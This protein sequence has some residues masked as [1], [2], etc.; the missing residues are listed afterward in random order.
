MP[1]IPVAL[2][3]LIA[4]GGCF[5]RHSEPPVP[6]RSAARDSLL[7]FDLR[8]VDSLALRG[9][10]A[11][12][13]AYLTADAVYLRGGAPFVFGRENVV[14]MLSAPGSSS[15]ATLGWQ[16]IGG[17]LSRD[18]LC[19]YS[20]GIAVHSVPERVVPAIDRY[21]AFW[22]RTRG[23]SWKIQ[24]YAEVGDNIA[25]PSSAPVAGITIPQPALSKAAAGVVRSLI[26]ADSNFAEASSLFGAARGFGDAIAD[27]GVV[28]GGSEILA[29]ARDVREFFESRRGVSMSWHPMFAMAAASGDLGFTIGES[30]STSRGPSGAAVQRFTKYITVWRRQPN[31]RWKFVVDGGNARPSPV[32]E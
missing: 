28:F 9:L 6:R 19:G 10:P 17:G 2:V 15:A 16:P 8:R 18:G 30:V 3:A 22:T 24:A 32:G 14:L 1:R 5:S 12:M 26:I 13:S 23:G 21:I 7:A 4:L 27:N 31:G 20:F 29:G 11:T 25:V